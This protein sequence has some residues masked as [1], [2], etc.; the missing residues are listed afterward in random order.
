MGR[1]VGKNAPFIIISRRAAQT[2][3]TIYLMGDRS[4][5]SVRARFLVSSLNVRNRKENA[6]VN[7]IRKELVRMTFRFKEWRAAQRWRVLRR[8]RP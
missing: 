4:N 5:R 6:V 3:S 8:Y 2:G 1:Q 7:I